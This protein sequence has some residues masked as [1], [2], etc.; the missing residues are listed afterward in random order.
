MSRETD[1][2]ETE[3]FYF[4]SRN[5][6]LNSW[7]LAYKTHDRASQ[8]SKPQN[9]DEVAAYN[10]IEYLNLAK[11]NSSIGNVTANTSFATF[12]MC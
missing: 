1:E 4:T 5:Y 10:R 7:E 12:T 9:D 3:V 2:E 8:K 6:Y 11:K